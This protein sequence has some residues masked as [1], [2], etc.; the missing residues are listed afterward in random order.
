MLL[1]F[2]DYKI[3]NFCICITN[4]FILPGLEMYFCVLNVFDFHVIRLR[5]T[6]SGMLCFQHNSS[7]ETHDLTMI[8]IS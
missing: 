4:R 3:K 8:F 7:K 1:G 6:V 2:G 5:L